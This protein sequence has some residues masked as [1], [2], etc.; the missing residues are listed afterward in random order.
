MMREVLRRWKLLRKTL[1]R[2]QSCK[3]A[4]GY[5]KW[6]ELVMFERRKK[7][8]R[9]CT[10]LVKSGGVGLM[11]ELMDRCRLL[12]RV[13]LRVLH[14]KTGLAFSKWKDT[15]PSLHPRRKRNCRCVFRLGHGYKCRCTVSRHLELRV[16]FARVSLDYAL[17]VH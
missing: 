14:I 11:M 16:S 15:I 2:A 4:A 6:Y 10:G 7:W 17:W 8:V 1:L 9:L 3:V 12:R 5:S 13:L